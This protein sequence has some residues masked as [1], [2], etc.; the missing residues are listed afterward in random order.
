MRVTGS[1]GAAVALCT[2]AM[3]CWLS[4]TRPAEAK[5]SLCGA[6][7][8]NLQARNLCF[9]PDKLSLAESRMP[10]GPV[11]P[12]SAVW[13]AAHLRLNEVALEM[14]PH[15][16]PFLVE[17][18]FGKILTDARACR[19]TLRRGLNMFGSSSSWDI[20]RVERALTWTCPSNR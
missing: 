3:G 4:A 9:G 15:R 7:F 10:A 5:A 20:K 18:L 6:G 19:R 1:A 16:P 17:Y 2:L 11:R 8:I 13:K 12:V 14:Y